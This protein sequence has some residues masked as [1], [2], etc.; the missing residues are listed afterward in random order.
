MKLTHS[1]YDVDGYFQLRGLTYML[2][3]VRGVTRDHS[4][5]EQRGC[6]SLAATD[7]GSFCAFTGCYRAMSSPAA[8]CN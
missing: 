1:T 6:R 8:S 7:L 2:R 4:V 3:F 5:H